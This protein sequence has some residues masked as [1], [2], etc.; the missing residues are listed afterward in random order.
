MWLL[1]GWSA[2]FGGAGFQVRCGSLVKVAK[3]TCGL[4]GPYDVTPDGQ[5]FV[6]LDTSE[7]Q[8]L[9]IQLNLVLNRFEEL[10]RLV[11]ADP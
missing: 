10:E 3:T 2:S 4:A 11:S 9:L 5:R 7:S 8:T 6:M 1:G